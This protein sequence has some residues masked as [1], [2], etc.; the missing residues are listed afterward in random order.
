[1]TRTDLARRSTPALA[2]LSL[3]ATGTF[4][5]ELDDVACSTPAPLHCADACAPELLTPIST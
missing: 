5:Q 1:M 3:A 4:A 2:L